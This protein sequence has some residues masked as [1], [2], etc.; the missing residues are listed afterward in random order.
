[1]TTRRFAPQ[2]LLRA[3]MLT[4]LAALASCDKP[5][6][7]PHVSV[8]G[9]Q[10]QVSGPTALAA[11]TIY[12]VRPSSSTKIVLKWTDASDSESSFS[13]FR[14]TMN[15]DSTFGTPEQVGERE[16]NSGTFVDSVGL[17]VGSTYRYHVS[18]CDATSCAASSEVTVA[19]TRPAAPTLYLVR[20]SSSTEIVLKWT[21]ASDNESSFR[22]FRAVQKADGTYGALQFVGDREA[23]S[24]TFVDSVGL[25]L[26]RTYRYQVG[27]CNAVGCARSSEVTVAFARPA[28]PTGVSAALGATAGTVDIS[29]TDPNTN[30][31][32]Q[33]IMRSRQRVD[34][35]WTG[36]VKVASTG[37]NVVS[38]QDPAVPAGTYRYQVRACN[39]VGCATSM[40][41]QNVTVP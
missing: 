37:P 6:L 16:A 36:P 4:M 28:P 39:L 30:E 25:V 2:G 9:A 29:W 17:V 11:P 31:I 12:L 24:G 13:I 3:G 8:P 23:N 34:G 18:A 20:P 14:A 19:F 27:A 15:A 33:F 40:A 35:S 10:L 1:M 21:D 22:I 7:L 38:Y 32:D 5:N 41:S 26:D